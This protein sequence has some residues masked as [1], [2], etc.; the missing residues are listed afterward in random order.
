[1]TANR[2]VAGTFNGFIPTST[3]SMVIGWKPNGESQLTFQL[4]HLV[5]AGQAYIGTEF[6]C[7]YAEDKSI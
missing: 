6:F 7:I 1:M 5:G 4:D 3:S 2:S